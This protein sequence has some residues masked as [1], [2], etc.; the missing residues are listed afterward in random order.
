MPY[1]IPNR[2]L[3]MPMMNIITAAL[4]PKTLL[5]MKQLREQQCKLHRLRVSHIFSI[6][7][8]LGLTFEKERKILDFPFLRQPF[9]ATKALRWLKC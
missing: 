4:N 3:T 2:A 8:L 9:K 1:V 7:L 6:A 5:S